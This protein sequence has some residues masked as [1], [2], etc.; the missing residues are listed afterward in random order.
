M[1][2]LSENPAYT[3]VLAHCAHLTATDPT[4]ASASTEMT[5]EVLAAKGLTGNP[6]SP[7]IAESKTI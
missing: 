4:L 1:P 6:T 3:E 7:Q 5:K 2:E